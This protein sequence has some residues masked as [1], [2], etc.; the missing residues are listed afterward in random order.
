MVRKKKYRRKER[1]KKRKYE[2]KKESKEERKGESKKEKKKERKKGNEK[3]EEQHTVSVFITG[4]IV[5]EI[6]S[7]L[8]S[9]LVVSTDSAISVSF[10]IR[11]S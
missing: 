6:S 9:V 7:F 8:V 11:S 3:K 4:C 1:K 10:F 5:E 2:R